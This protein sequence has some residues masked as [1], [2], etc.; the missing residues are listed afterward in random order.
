MKIGNYTIDKELVELFAPVLERWC[1]ID[2]DMN[3]VKVLEEMSL[4]WSAATQL[5]AIK[6]LRT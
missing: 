3:N 1:S 2:S 5:D 4:F 6:K